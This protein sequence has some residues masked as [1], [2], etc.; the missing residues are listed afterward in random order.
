MFSTFQTFRKMIGWIFCF[1]KF[2]FYCIFV[3]SKFHFTLLDW[4]R[5]N[6][7]LWNVNVNN[8]LIKDNVAKYWEYSGDIKSKTKHLLRIL[9]SLNFISL[10]WSGKSH[11]QAMKNALGKS[12][13]SPQMLWYIVGT[14]SEILIQEVSILSL[15]S[16]TT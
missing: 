11:C 5:L 12:W 16:R 14:V 13:F 3:V 8:K 10:V 15:F 4:L 2:L 7:P 9:H 6:S 1:L